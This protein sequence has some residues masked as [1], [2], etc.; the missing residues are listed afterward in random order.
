MNYRHVYML[1]IEHA[2]SEMENGLRPKSS[3]Y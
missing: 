2:K 3:Y 1:I